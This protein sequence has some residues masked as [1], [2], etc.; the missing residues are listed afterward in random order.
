MCAHSIC[1][2]PDIVTRANFSGSRSCLSQDEISWSC[3]TINM[4]INLFLEMRHHTLRGM[5]SLPT[6]DVKYTHGLSDTVCSQAT[7]GAHKHILG[8][9]QFHMQISLQDK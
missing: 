7:L 8:D 1:V 2:C 5:A 9:T 6:A 3:T 4:H